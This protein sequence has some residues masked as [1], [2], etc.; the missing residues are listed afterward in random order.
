[1]GNC[2]CKAQEILD[3]K[4]ISS[5]ITLTSAKGNHEN[6][7][8]LIE[9]Y[10]I[11]KYYNIEEFMHIIRSN[12]ED[13]IGVKEETYNIVI[14]KKFIKNQQVSEWLLNDDKAR[15][16]ISDFHQKFFSI[17]LKAFKTYYKSLKGDKYTSSSLPI[18]LFLP[19]GFLYSKGRVDNKIDMIFNLFCNK[20]QILENTDEFK[21]FV[22]ASLSIPAGITLFILKIL[23][24]ENEEYKAKIEKFEFESIFDTYQIKDAINA[25]NEYFKLLFPTNEKKGLS[26]NE[27]KI[28]YSTNEEV[29]VLFS[30]PGVRAFLEKHNI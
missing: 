9:D 20:E 21:M 2:I 11:F 6:I 23:A 18:N 24:D 4:T 5:D 12:Y 7:F 14:E 17:Y 29:Q 15:M 22:F 1:M 25:T 19:F 3:K 8:S 28:L 27:F 30:A 16:K 13:S 26:Y 10:N